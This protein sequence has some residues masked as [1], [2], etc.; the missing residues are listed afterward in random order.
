ML[1]ESEATQVTQMHS[2]QVLDIA[3]TNTGVQA[4]QMGT[5]LPTFVAI[6]GFEIKNATALHTV[7]E[8]LAS[9]AKAEEKE[10]KGRLEQTEQLNT[11]MR[12]KLSLKS[13]DDRKKSELANKESVDTT[14]Q[15]VGD[16]ER[17]QKL[18]KSFNNSLS[19]EAANV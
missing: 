18:N 16:G 10:S 11:E 1:S 2:V 19:S 12:H 3:S 8:A 17:D 9:N 15:D 5:T 14:R 6:A 7:T 4:L 13:E